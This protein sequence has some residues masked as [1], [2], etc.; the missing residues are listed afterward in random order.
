MSPE[1]A[2]GE[3]ADRQ[4]DIWSFGV[5]LYELLTGVS[6]FVRN[7]VTE[8]LAAVLDARVD[9]ARLPPATPA[10]VRHVLRRCLQPDRKRRLLHIGDAR[11]DLEDSV[12]DRVSDITS[13]Q[14]TVAAGRSRWSVIAAAVALVLLPG[15]GWLLAR[16]T[17]QQSPAVVRLSIPSMEPSASEAV[18]QRH[19]AV[20]PDGSRVA[21]VSAS[22]LWIRDIGRDRATR[23]PTLGGSAPFFSPDGNWVGFFGSRD[24][25]GWL[26][27]KVPASG[28]TPVQ[29]AV[30]PDRPGG[31]TWGADGAIVFA[32]TGGLYQVSAAGGEGQVLVK[33]D[34]RRKERGYAWPEFLP[35]GHSVLF[36]VVPEDSIDGAQIA[37]LDLNTREIRS[38]VRGGTAARYVP[39]GH[40]V[41][42]AGAALNAISFDATRRTTSGAPVTIADVAI[43][44]ASDNG[45]AEFA[46]SPAGTLLFVAPNVPGEAQTMMTWVDRVGHEEPLGLPPGRYRTG[47]VSP[48]GARVALA[49][50]GANSDIWIWDV[51]RSISTKLTNG[52]KEDTQP[53]WNVDGRRVY[54]ASNRTGDS[55]VYSQS[56]DGATDARLELAAEGAQIPHGITDDGTALLI[57]E[58]FKDVS[59]L[60]LGGTNRLE[61]LLHSEFNEWLTAVSPD[62]RWIAY[63]SNESG[64]RMDIFLR[65][66]PNVSDR[67][68]KISINGG[69]SPKWRPKGGGELYYLDLDGH[70]MA[71]SIRL[72]PTLAVGTVT[73]LFDWLP[74][75]Q[76]VS[77]P[78]YDVSP[79][80]GRFLMV[81]P[82]SNGATH[83]DISVVLNWFQELRTLVPERQ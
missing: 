21:Y 17:G 66:F 83:S 65:P 81:K 26:L 63:E 25:A 74:P 43:M 69:R 10:P 13:N 50:P 38:L 48:D 51:K 44:T 28:G 75:P 55:D 71:V 12:I 60:R 54:F 47:R 4:A 36:T 64:D 11:I 31:G 76:G 15:I 57:N 67:R 5:V 72:A 39:T 46:V 80:D 29:I 33:P 8:T 45:A 30:M 73:K 3:E 1:Q 27:L 22:A 16:G 82:I 62:G 77:G 2:R 20:S 23:I 34:S 37:L 41:Y 7:S 52:P 78:L 61:P 56:A 18:G 19:L 70:M 68:E 14:P 24:G 40:I 42:A 6:P 35:D 53:V 49:I 32:S 58:K 79:V 59:V 9:L